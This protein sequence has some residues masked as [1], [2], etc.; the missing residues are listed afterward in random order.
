MVLSES[1]YG[2]QALSD[3][4]PLRDLFGLLFFA[5]V[6]MLLDPEFLRDHVGE[7]AGLVLAV[8]LGKAIVFALLTRLFGYRN[9]VPLAVGLGL[10][11]IGEF[12]FVLARVGV[13]TGSIGS[14]LFSLV[15]TAAI[16]T[17]ALTPIVAGQTAR[18]YALRKR[19]FHHEPLESANLPETGLRNHVVI[20]GAGR[21]GFQIAT[22]LQ[23]LGLHFVAIEL[24]QPRVERAKNAG[25]PVVYGDASQEPVLEAAELRA[26]CLLLITTPGIVE[27]RSI[28]VNSRRLNSRL[29]IVA[30][31][32]DAEF[33]P[34]L[35]ALDV[36]EVVLP[37][38]EAGLE[39]TRQ[40][41]VHLRIPAPEIQ[42]HTE[43]LREEMLSPKY[44]SAPDYKL[45]T[46]L[47][48]A[49]Q[50]FDLQWA[51]LD[52]ASPL[53]GVSIGEAHVRKVTGA[54]IVGV[55]RGDDLEPNP[56]AGFRF[57][58]GRQATVSPARPAIRSSSV[59]G[60]GTTITWKSSM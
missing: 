30:R 13:S 1:D 52:P 36:T 14:E 6:G 55:I 51:L 49:E 37:E 53:V 59:D 43:S 46:Q 21:I 42:R 33:L 10:F 29:H 27:G 25:M 35:R 24:D 41:L 48:S 9:I 45:L 5:S 23:K 17:M 26:A 20:A 34:T 3:I 19:W 7:V 11:Q 8:G 40:A 54:S 16:L 4:I 22:T 56:A 12:S 28:V 15:L 18:L 58:P 2:H 38:F 32:A 57:R 39:M 31:A 60:S 50:Q 47:R 44:R